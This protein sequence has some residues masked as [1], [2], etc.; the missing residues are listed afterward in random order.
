MTPGRSYTQHPTTRRKDAVST[1]STRAKGL[2]YQNKTLHLLARLG[3]ATTRQIA[4][5]VWGKV[6]AS[7]K[8]MATRTLNALLE[9]G[10][11][12]ERREDVNSDR[13]VALTKAG[14]ERLR[15]VVGFGLVN[16]RP[17]ARD[18]LRHAHD[19]R[20]AANSVF[21]AGADYGFDIEMERDDW[22]GLT[23]LEIRGD[24][25]TLLREAWC[26]YRSSECKKERKLAD[27]VLYR[28]GKPIWVEV[29]NCDRG[30]SDMSKCV[31]WLR[32][33]YTKR[34]PEAEQVWF[35]ITA[36]GAARIGRRLKAALTP[37]DFVND[38]RPRQAKELD[39]RILRERRVRVFSLNADTLEL[40]ELPL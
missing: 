5:G 19:H 36:P 21:V 1:Q 26:D 30:T 35:V 28:D 23:E 9:A 20:T 7:T 25:Q 40:T 3:Y 39:E 24:D 32:A 29:E 17:H 37:G 6:T 8:K 22:L 10:L 4:R 14:V 27:A 12:V 2:D 33:M 31:D 34:Q 11:L 15:T 18:W 16:G 13:M 38:A